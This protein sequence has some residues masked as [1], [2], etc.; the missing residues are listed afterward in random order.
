MLLD[1]GGGDKRAPRLLPWLRWQP[2]RSTVSSYAVRWYSGAEPGKRR[3]AS[4]RRACPIRGAV[5]RNCRAGV[6]T[7]S[8]RR[9]W[10]ST[11]GLSMAAPDRTIPLEVR[12]DRRL[13]P[14][15]PID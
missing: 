9:V 4:R 12:R 10:R 8:P 1:Y 6:I 13:A 2:S 14:G 3:H 5:L 11:V 7:V 15:D